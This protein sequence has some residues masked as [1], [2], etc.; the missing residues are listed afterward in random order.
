MQKKGLIVQEKQTESQFEDAKAAYV[1]KKKAKQIEKKEERKEEITIKSQR[2][3]VTLAE[4]LAPYDGDKDPIIDN[5]IQD[6]PCILSQRSSDNEQFVEDIPLFETEPENTLQADQSKKVL[7]IAQGYEVKVG[8]EKKA[9]TPS[10]KKTESHKK[11]D[12]SFESS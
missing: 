7:N 10:F 8:I 6:R 2:S 9:T 4:E 11:A 1:N 3:N 5:Q 12:K